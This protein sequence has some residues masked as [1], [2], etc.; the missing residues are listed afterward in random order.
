MKVFLLKDVVKIGAKGEIIKVE[1]G[2]GK[3]Y[4]IPRGFA[5]EV[6]DHNESFFLNQRRVLENRKEAIETETSLLATRITQIKLTIK[7]KMH[8]NGQLY[9]SVSGTEIA[10]LLANQGI[11][12][13][14]N[15]IIFDRSSIKGKG[16]YDVGIKLSARLQPQ[17]KLVVVPEK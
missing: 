13:S 7:K 4:L 9:G 16:T 1:D 10:E 2:F 6:T 15:Q 17:L 8:D 11:K 14:K 5:K 12:V 3:N